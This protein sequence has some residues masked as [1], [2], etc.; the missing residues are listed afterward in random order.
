MDVEDNLFDELADKTKGEAWECVSE[1]MKV[2]EDGFK[3]K[4]I[5]PYWNTISTPPLFINKKKRFRKA[6]RS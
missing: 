1:A 5:D 2:L 4:L 3:A 6:L